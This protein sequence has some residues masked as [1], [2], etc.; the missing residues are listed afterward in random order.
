MAHELGH[1]MGSAHDRRN[2]SG[3]ASQLFSFGY[4]FKGRSNEIWHTIMAVTRD[5]EIPFFSNPQL[6]F[7]GKPIGVAA[8]EDNAQSIALSAG[9]IANYYATLGSPDLALPVPVEP[10]RV[11]FSTKRKGTKIVLTYRVLQGNTPIPYAPMEAYYAKGKKG[12]S[13][14]R[15]VG[16][17]NQQGTFT[18]KE[19]A[20]VARGFFY[21]ACYLGARSTPLCSSSKELAKVK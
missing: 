19:S 5:R 6:T 17:A 3:P 1:N 12:R 14:L 7:D 2:A 18:F 15:A 21:K 9:T 10:T 8:S 11:T 20:F 4:Q 13:V 16:R